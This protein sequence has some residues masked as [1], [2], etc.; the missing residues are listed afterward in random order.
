MKV[1][2]ILE[3]IR[4]INKLKK[5][6]IIKD[7]AIGGGIAK[8]YYL[9]PQSTYDL[10]IFILIDTMDDFHNIYDYFRKKKYR[11]ENIFIIIQDVPVQF[12]PSFIHPLIEQAIK[13]GKQIK[14][15]KLK[16]KILTVEYLIATL[17]MAFR[18]KDKFAIKELL[19][20]ANLDLLRRLLKRF[21][22]KDYPLYERF[23]KIKDEKTS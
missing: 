6:R 17:L 12:L 11:I 18:E 8:N 20:F 15:D 4:E 9:E 14:V 23:K 21:S 10:D 5:K 1:K 13:N 19:S 2:G 16:S 3:L 22:S 7:Y